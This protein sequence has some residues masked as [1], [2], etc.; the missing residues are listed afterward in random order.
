MLQI[1]TVSMA[2]RNDAYFQGAERWRIGVRQPCLSEESLLKILSAWW[3]TETVHGLSA[4][5]ALER[6]QTRSGRV[7]RLHPRRRNRDIHVPLV[8]LGHQRTP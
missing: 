2:A 6:I 3:W 4:S 8:C 5:G 1:E 7:C